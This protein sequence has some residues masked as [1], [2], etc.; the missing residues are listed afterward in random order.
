MTSI[1]MEIYA[2]C[3]HVHYV[4]LIRSSNNNAMQLFMPS[5]GKLNR[6]VKKFARCVIAPQ[7]AIIAPQA[8]ILPSATF[9]S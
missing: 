6:N 8:A 3:E 2:I 4:H 1:C 9:Y 7:A 5:V